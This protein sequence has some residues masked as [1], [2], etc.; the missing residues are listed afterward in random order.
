MTP[1]LTDQEI[2]D[3]C[4]GLQNNAAKMRH[5]RGMGLVVNRKP[6]GRALVMRNH[7]ECWTPPSTTPAPPLHVSAPW[8]VFY[9]W[10]ALRKHW[11]VSPQA[12]G[13][14]AFFNHPKGKS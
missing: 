13:Q 12:V 10:L 9:F 3:L 4:D 14:P 5:L 1:W 7:A 6:N 8:R 2:N 11:K